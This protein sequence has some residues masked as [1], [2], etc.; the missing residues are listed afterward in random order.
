MDDLSERNASLAEQ[1]QGVEIATVVSL[2]GSIRNWINC[3]G[4]KSEYT[5]HRSVSLRVVF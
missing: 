1:A 5:F 4:L 2:I 3:G